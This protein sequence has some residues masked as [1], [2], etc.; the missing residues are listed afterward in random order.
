M[1][2]TKELAELRIARAVFEAE[3]AADELANRIAKLQSIM[4]EARRDLQ[5]PR[6]QGRLRCYGSE[7]LTDK[8]LQ[9]RPRSTACTANCLKPASRS[10]MSPTKMAIVPGRTRLEG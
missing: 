8:R 7:K 10:R 5:L 4:L 6:R 1:K 3:E 2:L 9:L